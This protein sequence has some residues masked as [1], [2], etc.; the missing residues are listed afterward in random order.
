MNLIKTIK[1]NSPNLY[2]YRYNDKLIKRFTWELNKRVKSRLLGRIGG[3]L[4]GGD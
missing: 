1:L 3:H 2:K 4:G